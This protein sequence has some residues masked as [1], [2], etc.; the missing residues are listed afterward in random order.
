MLNPVCIGGEILSLDRQ[1]I[2]S[3]NRLKSTAYRVLRGGGWL[4]DSEGCRLLFRFNG[5]AGLHY[6][7]IGFRLLGL[8]SGS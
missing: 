5:G 7:G 3:K 6:S 8:F 4:H 2:V 1:I